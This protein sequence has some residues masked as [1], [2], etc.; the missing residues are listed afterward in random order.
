MVPKS[1]S[2]SLGLVCW[3]QLLQDLN[4]FTFYHTDYAIKLLKYGVICYHWPY[5][6]DYIIS[7]CSEIAD[8]M[9]KCSE[10]NEQAF[11]KY[12]LLLTLTF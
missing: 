4:T 6:L 7:R 9:M 3:Q 12:N 8:D 5:R 1:R 2:R 11:S 10:L